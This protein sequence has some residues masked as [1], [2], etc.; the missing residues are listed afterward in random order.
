M[1]MS[2]PTSSPTLTPDEEDVKFGKSFARSARMTHTK[3][4]PDHLPRLSESVNAGNDSGGT[5][6]EEDS[7]IEEDLFSGGVMGGTVPTRAGNSSY[8][9]EVDTSP[10]PRDAATRRPPVLDSLRLGTESFRTSMRQLEEG[11]SRAAAT[12]G[13]TIC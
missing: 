1:T 13:T 4:F 8:Q 9:V 6:E 12:A 3:T 5:V 11:V 7:M 10:P 2:S